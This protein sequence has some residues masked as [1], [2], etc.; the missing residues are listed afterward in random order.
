MNL[1]LLKIN[2]NNAIESNVPDF[3]ENVANIGLGLLE[4]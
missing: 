1:I 4:R 3:G 2:R